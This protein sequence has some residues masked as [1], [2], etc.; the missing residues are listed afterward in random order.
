MGRQLKYYLNFQWNY[1][2]LYFKQL[3]WVLNITS[4]EQG[5]QFMF[6]RGENVDYLR[7]DYSTRDTMVSRKTAPFLH[8]IVGWKR[9]VRI[10]RITAE[11]ARG[12][13]AGRQ[14]HHQH[15]ITLH[16]LT[17]HFSSCVYHVYLSWLH[18]TNISWNKYERTNDVWLILS[19][20]NLNNLMQNRKCRFLDTSSLLLSV[21]ACNM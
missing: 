9:Q 3:H 21:K 1:L 10:K 19:H 12:I 7:F 6:N 5:E 11:M 13:K 15:V 18:M 2:K 16:L 20:H 8:V 14:S 17:S 4:M